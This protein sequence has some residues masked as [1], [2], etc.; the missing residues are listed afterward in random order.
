MRSFLSAKRAWEL[1]TFGRDDFL[2]EREYFCRCDFALVKNLSILKSWNRLHRFI[3][4][5]RHFF[6]Y[7]NTFTCDHF[8]APLAAENG[9]HQDTRNAQQ[10]S[11]AADLPAIFL[12]IDLSPFEFVARLK[13]S[14]GVRVQFK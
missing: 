12:V 8:R 4:I 3:R 14:L 5:L 7:G 1:R 13:V 2:I 10:V 9:K 11:V 6:R